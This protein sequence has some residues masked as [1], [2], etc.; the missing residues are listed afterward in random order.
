MTRLT[1]RSR[2]AGLAL[3]LVSAGVAG[4]TVHGSSG[5]P[6]SAAPPPAVVE[7]DGDARALHV[8]HPEQFPLATA[9][10]RDAAPELSVTGVVGPDVS[11]SVPVVSLAG[12]RVIDL[13][14][15]LGDQV[16][17]G[18]VLLRIESPDVAAAFSDY[19]KAVADRVLADRQLDR[20][21]TLL[22]RGAIAEKDAEIARDAAA[23]AR[24]DEDNAVQRLRLLG[25]NLDHPEAPLVDVVAPVSGVV[26]EQNVTTAAGVK[27]LDNSP[28]LFTISDLSR[29]WIVCDVPENDLGAVHAGD[30][31]EIRLSAY[32]GRTFSGRIGNIG[33][34]LDPAIRTAKVR[35]ELAND[36]LFRVGMFV[37]ATFRGR[38]AETRVVIPAAAVLH[39]HEHDWVYVAAAAGGFERREVVAGAMLDGDRQELRS[40]LRPGDRVVANALVFQSTVEQ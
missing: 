19:R 32:P 25:A 22:E 26:T 13:R 7:H 30:A 12:G 16:R 35:V 2:G 24:V 23:K 39:L 40:G 5:E 15:R 33:A 28:N 3:A 37:T 14:A 9:T 21:T 20:A 11:R 31:A 36:G 38:S 17:K 4:C 34:I 29:V 6:A 27:S 18:Q 1:V 10:A 8:D